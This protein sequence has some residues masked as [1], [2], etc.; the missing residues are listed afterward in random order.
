MLNNT[1]SQKGGYAVCL[2]LRKFINISCESIYSGHPKK[3]GCFP[4]DKDLFWGYIV[5][6]SI[7]NT[8]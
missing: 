7:I 4:L 8:D 1:T 3:C 5:N 6:T 2:F